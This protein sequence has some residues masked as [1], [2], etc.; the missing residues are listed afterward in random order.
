[1][2]YQLSCGQLAELRFPLGRRLVRGLLSA[3]GDE[4][5]YDR[6]R[7]AFVEKATQFD[8][9]R[10][11]LAFVIATIADFKVE[12]AASTVELKEIRQGCDLRLAAMPHN[13]RKRR[14]KR[15]R[16]P[17]S[18]RI[19]EFPRVMTQAAD[20]DASIKLLELRYRLANDPDAE[21]KLAYVREATSDIARSAG[22]E[23]AVAW[24]EA[25]DDWKT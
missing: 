6:R 24:L 16:I 12:R 19:V 25:S 23:A 14:P 13:P 18:S 8:D 2:A 4:A 21:E 9:P 5:E 17:T 20:L 1:M 3:A 7:A 15:A 11:L 10:Q 22:F